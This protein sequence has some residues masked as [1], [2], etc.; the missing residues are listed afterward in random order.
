M[1]C[2]GYVSWQGTTVHILKTGRPSDDQTFHARCG[3]LAS[4]LNTIQSN[5]SLYMRLQIRSTY[6][7]VL[8]SDFNYVCTTKFSSQR[9]VRVRSERWVVAILQQT[10][11]ILRLTTFVEQIYDRKGN[12]CCRWVTGN[13]GVLLEEKTEGDSNIF[14]CFLATQRL[15]HILAIA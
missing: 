12:F 13:I 9:F 4:P 5:I 11:H 3:F 15:L 6:T 7:I 10:I 8:S 2:T 14:C 1:P